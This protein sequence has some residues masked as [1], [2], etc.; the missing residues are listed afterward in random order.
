MTRNIIDH[1]ELTAL[2]AKSEGKDIATSSELL[3]IFDESGKQSGLASRLLCHRL[4]LLH[5]VVYCFF[6][7]DDGQLLLQTRKGGRLDLAVGGHLSEDDRSA[8]EAILREIREEVGFSFKAD[9]L[10]RIGQYHRHTYD[11]LSKPRELNNELREL[12]LVRL[13]ASEC[14]IVDTVFQ[15]RHDKSAV[16]AV[17]WFSIAEVIDACDAGIAADG[18]AA[19]VAHYLNWNITS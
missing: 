11:R 9:R 5:K 1:L 12:F 7:N 16:L 8:G 14:E 3:P 18:L 13:S 17:D 15:K 4:G 6:E 10:L 19:S 2:V